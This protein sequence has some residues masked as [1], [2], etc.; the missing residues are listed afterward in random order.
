MKPRTTT[1]LTMPD[2]V[3]TVVED[4]GQR[5]NWENN[6]T[7]LEFL[8]Q[9]QQQYGW[10]N[11]KLDY[12]EGLVKTNATHPEIPAKFPGIDLESEQP[13]IT[14]QSKLSNKVTKNA[15]T[16]RSKTHFWT[17][18]QPSSQECPPQ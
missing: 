4:W 6:S 7:K 17:I 12:D 1:P 2:R 3:I 18:S 8:N 9:K 15:S 14:K 13:N 5:N 10:D 16:Q 11:N